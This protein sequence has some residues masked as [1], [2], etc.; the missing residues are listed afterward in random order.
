MALD[1]LERAAV[2]DSIDPVISFNR[3]LVLE[4]L[5]LV[6]EAGEQWERIAANAPAGLSDEARPHASTQSRLDRGTTNR[7]A[8]LAAP[9]TAAVPASLLVTMV[10]QEPETIREFALDVLL[11]SWGDSIIGGQPVAAQR[12]LALARRLGEALVRERGDSTVSAAANAVDQGSDT[13]RVGAALAALGLARRRFDA[14]ERETTRAFFQ[15]AAALPAL[16]LSAWPSLYLGVL[17]LYEH[18]YADADRRFSQLAAATEGTSLITLRAR[19][20][21]ASALSLARQDHPEE[22]IGG[23]LAAIALFE[24]A[25][26]RTNVAVM[27]QQ[28]ADMYAHTGDIPRAASSFLRAARA[29][30]A[31]RDRGTLQGFLQSFAA[32]ELRSDRAYGA[33][34][35]LREAVR[36]SRR[37]GRSSDPPEALARLAA[38]ELRVGRLGD[39]GAHLRSARALL[40]SIPSPM[41]RAAEETEIARVEARL[42]TGPDAVAKLDTVAAYYTRLGIPY[43][44]APTLVQRADARLAIHDTT[45]AEQDLDRAL[46]L[47]SQR[48]QRLDVIAAAAAREVERGVFERRI[49]IR[50][51]RGDSAV[52]L[53][54]I[55]GQRSWRTA[56]GPAVRIRRPGAGQAIVAYAVLPDRLVRWTVTSRG[57]STRVTPIAERELAAK[58]ARFTTSVRRGD[59]SQRLL[60]QSEDLHTLLIGA[61]ADSLDSDTRIALIVDPTLANLPFAA[62]RNPATRRMLVEDHELQYAFG[63]REGLDGLARSLTISEPKLALAGDFAAAGLPRLPQSAA[64]LESIRSLYP[65]ARVL[66]GDSVTRPNVTSGLRSASVFH[67]SGHA[68]TAPAGMLGSRLVLAGS[69]PNTMESGDIA[70]LDLRHLRLVVL[71]ACE[72][73]TLLQSGSYRMDG[74]AESFLA[75]GAGGVIGS[76]WPVEDTSTG[77]LMAE[78]YRGIRQGLSIAAALRAAQLASVRSTTDPARSL[79]TWAAFRYMT[80]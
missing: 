25:G 11:P 1:L 33:V 68:Q 18:R 64:E 29:F 51:E 24:R 10:D 8:L 65:G 2:L 20:L 5:H 55:D 23:Y 13:L 41:M 27:E 70:R 9:P 4:R 60:R 45:G 61:G 7:A 34:A 26:E 30:T 57:I 14:G 40:D 54:E 21:W 19:T 58:V 77:A 75:A 74:L 56:R 67:F 36:V 79:R 37:T 62:L 52:A 76:S 35:I 46:A 80:R 69:P 16:A 63:I 47:V 15:K 28:L 38:A 6:G 49:A 12:S 71:S 48:A 31:R 53:L 22:A 32:F 50:L 17:D 59:D 43:D 78:L 73:L 44:L 66:R 39:A 3:A 42:L 72:T